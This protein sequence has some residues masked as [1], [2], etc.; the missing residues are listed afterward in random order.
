MDQLCLPFAPFRRPEPKG[1]RSRR[2]LGPDRTAAAGQTRALDRRRRSTVD[3]ESSA[4]LGGC[5]APRARRA[6][7][8]RAP[9]DASQGPPASACLGAAGN[10]TLPG[11]PRV[12]RACLGLG[13]AARR[14]KGRRGRV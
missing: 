3:G 12:R 5:D 14:P 9:E 13:G 8:P 4:S 1:V 2:A 6:M 10:R 7:P 11:A